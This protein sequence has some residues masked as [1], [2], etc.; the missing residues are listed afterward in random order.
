MQMPTSVSCIHLSW[1]IRNKY[2]TFVFEARRTAGSC[3]TNTPFM[4]L[5]VCAYVHACVRILGAS[6][7]VAP[8]A[9][10]TDYPWPSLFFAFVECRQRFLA[11]SPKVA[12]PRL[13]PTKT[14]TRSYTRVQPHKYTGKLFL[15]QRK[16]TIRVW[17]NVWV[18]NAPQVM[19][20]CEANLTVR[21]EGAAGSHSGRLIR[22]HMRCCVSS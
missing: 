2:C 3:K 14:N 8:P 15:T 10:A 7:V 19:D 4:W 11:L 20:T 16:L 9:P 13:F 18:S 22:H 17:H 21:D 6:P 12:R 1:R 5:P